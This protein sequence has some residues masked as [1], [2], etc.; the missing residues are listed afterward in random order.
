MDF[1]ESV[2]TDGAAI[3]VGAM[4]KDADDI[5]E[6]HEQ[7]LNKFVETKNTVQ[8][9]AFFSFPFCSRRPKEWSIIDII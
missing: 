8:C 5:N 9:Y 3:A 1:Y 6:L 4:E 7:V 2:Y